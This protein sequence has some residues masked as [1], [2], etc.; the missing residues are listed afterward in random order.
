MDVG[1]GVYFVPILNVLVLM[2]DIVKGAVTVLP[3]VITWS[4]LLVYITL[5]LGFAYT[6]FRREGVI[7]RS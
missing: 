5:L 2:D 6:N 3:V 4:S 7:F 1:S